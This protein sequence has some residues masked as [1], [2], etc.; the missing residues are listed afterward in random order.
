M[1]YNLNRGRIG[2]TL[3][4]AATTCPGVARAGSTLTITMFVSTWRGVSLLSQSINTK[5]EHKIQMQNNV[6]DRE[7]CPPSFP[8]P[9]D[10]LCNHSCMFT[11]FTQPSHLCRLL[12][13]SVID[14]CRGNIDAQSVQHT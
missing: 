3:A 14:T 13:K 10:C 12:L 4:R 6:D 11:V 5:Y 9:D 8:N 1:T 2:K 7:L